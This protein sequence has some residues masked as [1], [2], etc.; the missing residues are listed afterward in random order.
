MAEMHIP[1]LYIPQ[2]TTTKPNE[3]YVSIYANPPSILNKKKRV[4]VVINDHNQDLGIWS[5]RAM[6]GDDGNIDLGSGIGL[7]K[8]I[9]LR[10][11]EAGTGS[12]DEE[13][14]LIIL[15][16]G[17]LLYSY[18]KKRPMSLTTWHDKIRKY[19]AGASDSIH[20]KYNRVEGNRSFE[21][22][23]SFVFE[24]IVKDSQWVAADAQV[25]VIGIQEGGNATLKYLSDEWSHYCRRI[26]AIAL[27][28]PFNDMAGLT[29]PFKVFLA[30]RG[31]AWIVSTAPSGTVL[32]T[33]SYTPPEEPQLTE[34]QWPSEV[35]EFTHARVP[36]LCPEFSSEEPL[37]AEVVFVKMRNTIL[38]WFEEVAKHPLSYCNPD[39][40]VVEWKE[41][42]L[43]AHIPEN[44]NL[45]ATAIPE[46]DAL[47]TET[48]SDVAAQPQS[49]GRG[50]AGDDLVEIVD[51]S[52]VELDRHLLE[53]AGL[54]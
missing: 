38:D 5:Y 28:S 10:S 52:D 16:P 9:Q 15:N 30:N 17:Q 37:Y 45:R 51:G 6:G 18:K 27:I 23:I 46:L 4:V 3:R 31:R 33:P 43:E 11:N 40:E 7:A 12:S 34:Y 32:D 36:P 20:E 39:F 13:P 42:V 2:L 53:G 54:L 41:P 24:K 44:P 48:V 21:E 8:E 26:A 29:T 50:I 35:P 49:I 14:G 19:A 22:H 1:Q 47:E 25:Y